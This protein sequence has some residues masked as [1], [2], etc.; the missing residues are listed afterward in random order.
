MASPLL[1]IANSYILFTRP[2]VP[3]VTS[4]RIGS[5]TSTKYLVKA[6]LK[7]AQYGGVSSGSKKIPLES[8]LEGRM[9]PGAAGDQFYYRGYGLQYATVANTFI[10]GT[11]TVT[12][13]SWIT[14]SNQ[15]TW[16]LPGN[17]VQVQF[18]N[19]P[20]LTGKIERS[21]GV[22]GGLGIDE[23]IYSEIGGVELQITG[24]ELEN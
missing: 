8:Q 23:I 2:G 12:G 9:L 17:Q 7:R 5:A 13:I 20:L 22:F 14:L 4:G 18:G 21:S 11:T 19:D 15:E 24:N 1:G 10:L 16:M 6:Y 3:T